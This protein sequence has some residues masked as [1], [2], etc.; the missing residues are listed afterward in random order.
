MCVCLLDGESILLSH[1]RFGYLERGF[2]WFIGSVGASAPCPP[3]YIT[4]GSSRV[5][6]WNRAQSRSY[7]G[8]T[9]RERERERERKRAREIERE[10]ERERERENEREREREIE[11]RVKR[12]SK[13]L[14]IEC[15]LSPINGLSQSLAYKL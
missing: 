1:P 7:K 4:E 13:S 10:R 5:T 14:K 2:L 9:V 3:F 11:I 8:Q 6:F 15:D 12:V